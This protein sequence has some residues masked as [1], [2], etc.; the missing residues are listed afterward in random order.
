MV[1]N[2]CTQHLWTTTE[3]HSNWARCHIHPPKDSTS[4]S[5]QLYG[6]TS[7][8]VRHIYARALA[9][10]QEHPLLVSDRTSSAGAVC[11]HASCA[12]CPHTDPYAQPQGLADTICHTP[13][14]KAALPCPSEGWARIHIAPFLYFCP[15]FV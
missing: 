10:I 4:L 8:A 7:S 12:I 15:H 11:P 2:M 9:R 3:P 14:S 6:Y 13:S 5:V 1:L